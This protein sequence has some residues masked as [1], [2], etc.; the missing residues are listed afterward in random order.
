[1][2]CGVGGQGVVFA[3]RL[4]GMAAMAMGW[5]VIMSEVHGMAQRGGSVVSHLRLGG[6]RSP[7]V[8]AASAQLLLGFTAAEARRGLGMV[9]PGGMVVV[10]APGAQALGEDALEALNK[11][12][13]RVVAVD[14]HSAGG[15]GGVNMIMLGAAAAAGVVPM[16]LEGL[17]RAVAGG[18]RAQENLRLLEEGARL[19]ES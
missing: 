10:N 6:A 1:M 3:A 9:A 12:G 2:I 5:S 17:K 11:A 18:K 8:P 15:G 4:V 14:A 19:T 16:G 13:V 7:L